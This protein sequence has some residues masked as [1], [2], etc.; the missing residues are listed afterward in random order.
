MLPHNTQIV[1]TESST[2]A[3]LFTQPP[4][5][6]VSERG[7]TT[8]NSTYDG[9][10]FLLRHVQAVAS[11]ASWGSPEVSIPLELSTARVIL[12]NAHCY[13]HSAETN[14]YFLFQTSLVAQAGL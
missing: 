1:G 10:A 4:S 3:K 2:L 14:Y 5:R 6:L 8:R 11:K 12:P 9:V 13:L 7:M